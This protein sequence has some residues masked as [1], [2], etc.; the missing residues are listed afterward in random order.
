MRIRGC[1][2]TIGAVLV[3]CSSAQAAEIPASGTLD[4]ATGADVRITGLEES[5]FTGFSV[6]RIGDV[7]GD[8]LADVAVGAPQANARDRANAGSVFV[9]FGR[10]DAAPVDLT[11]LGDG[12][13]RIDGAVAGDEAGLALAPAGD[14]NGDGRGDLVVGAPAIGGD[15][16]GAAYVVFGKPDSGGIDL[17]APGSSAYR[18]VGAQPGDFTGF[19]VAAVGDLDGDG[20]GE[21]LVGAPRFDVDAGDRVD[22]GAVYVVHGSATPA[23]VNLATLGAGLSMGRPT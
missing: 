15:R 16:L 3:A 4:L 19:S 9:I 23:D 21:L 2:A 5:S 11:N 6:S 20:I 22:G 14:L 7:N 10:A 17:A 1:L 8:G 18:I 13:Y 12:G